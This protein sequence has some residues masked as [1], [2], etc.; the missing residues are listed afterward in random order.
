[1][2]KFRHSNLERATN[3]TSVTSINTAIDH[4]SD[5]SLVKLRQGWKR[6][7]GADPPAVRSREFLLR[8]FSWQI[9]T[10]AFGGLDA[11][12]DKKLRA[13]AEGFERSPTFQPKMN[14]V[15][16]PGVVLTREWK[17]VVHK[18]TARAGGFEYGGR[19]YKS[20]S[21]VARTI[22]GTRWSGP[23]FFGLELKKRKSAGGENP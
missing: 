8:Q 15:L 1:M 13:I 3:R 19:T 4:L 9:Q 22:T 17:G 6:Q 7:F 10:Q 5:L 18:V 23:R 11:A 14:R 12:T 20:L 2:P 21:D 16:R